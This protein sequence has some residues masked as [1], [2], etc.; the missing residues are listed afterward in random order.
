LQRAD[1]TDETIVDLLQPTAVHER[2]G[3]IILVMQRGAALIDAVEREMRGD[4]I[5]HC[6]SP[7]DVERERQ[8]GRTSQIERHSPLF[9][10]SAVD[11]APL[12]IEKPRPFA[13]LPER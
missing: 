10:H 3:F 12:D 6:H 9:D 11:I 1:I 13:G 5:F 2:P 4:P 7:P 8:L